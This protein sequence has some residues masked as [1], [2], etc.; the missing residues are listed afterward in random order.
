VDKRIKEMKQGKEYSKKTLSPYI[1]FSSGTDS[2]IVRREFF[3]GKGGMLYSQGL[4][5]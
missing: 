5:S 3:R 2:Q 4:F 1:R